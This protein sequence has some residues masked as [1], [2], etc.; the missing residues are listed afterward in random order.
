ML[1]CFWY[2][3]CNMIEVYGIE[4]LRK[5][6]EQ[7]NRGSYCDIEIHIEDNVFYGHKCILAAASPY[8]ES[9]IVDAES[10][11]IDQTSLH[12]SKIQLNGISHSG[13][14]RLFDFMYTGKLQINEE[15]VNDVSVA[16]LILDISVALDCCAEFKRKKF[17]VASLFKNNV[18]QISST[19]CSS[20]VSH[21]QSKSSVETLM[22][23]DAQPALVS[24]KNEIQINEV[25]SFSAMKPRSEEFTENRENFLT[26]PTD[27]IPS[28]S[29]S[30]TESLGISLGRESYYNTTSQ[31]NDMISAC[32]NF[33]QSFE[34]MNNDPSAL[35]TLLPLNGKDRIM[36]TTTTEN[37]G[38]TSMLESPSNTFESL[39][40]R[41]NEVSFYAEQTE[42]NGVPSWK[43]KV[44]KK[45][46]RKL[47]YLKYVHVRLHNG[48][49]PHICNLCGKPF[50]T[51]GNLLQ[52]HK[53]HLA[54]NGV[55][56][57][58]CKFCKRA[59]SLKGNCQKHE[60]THTKPYRCEFCSKVFSVKND[61]MQHLNKHHAEQSENP[62]I[63]LRCSKCLTLFNERFGDDYFTHKCS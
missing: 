36:P 61:C 3:R 53:V 12:R 50:A 14:E 57:F 45:V 43:C 60:K 58:K 6:L 18:L 48:N 16:A 26:S 5:L 38:S 2:E 41:F 49:R 20:S 15:T 1:V 39:D 51:R 40:E 47:S 25:V 59:F 22:L 11:Y 63:G 19:E 24:P 46:F 7:R 13:F 29:E 42:K 56:P 55:L 54:K 4:L 37:A 28:H 17:S 27:R 32:A 9:Y 30:D 52:H 31:G 33:I 21:Q 62:T 44:C 34:A 10:K 35:P 23:Q 8:L